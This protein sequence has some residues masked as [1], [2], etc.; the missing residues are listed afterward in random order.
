M[1]EAALRIKAYFP[2]PR[3]LDDYNPLNRD[4]YS[5][6]RRPILRRSW[7]LHNPS[8]NWDGPTVV[9]HH[10]AANALACQLVPLPL[11]H[12]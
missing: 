5:T 1:P 3:S 11:S 4:L 12:E 10:H 8:S 6:R 9:W 2:V 7:P